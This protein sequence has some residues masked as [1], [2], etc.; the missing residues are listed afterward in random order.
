MLAATQGD[1]ETMSLLLE[2]GANVE[3]RDSSQRTVLHHCCR[4]GRLDNLRLLLEGE[5]AITNVA[6]YEYRTIG[7]IT[8]LMSAI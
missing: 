4:G 2:L 1:R 3:A 5:H 6:M 7:G 8:P